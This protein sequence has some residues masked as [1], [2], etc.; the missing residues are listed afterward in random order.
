MEQMIQQITT[1]IPIAR[2]LYPKAIIHWVFDNSSAHGS[3]AKDAL[4]A[5]K[6]N[7]NPGGKVPDM[8]DTVIPL[9]NPYGHGGKIQKMTFDKDL[10]ADHPHKQFEG[11]PKGMK[12]ILS[13]RGYTKNGEGK[14]LIGECKACKASKSRKPHLEGASADEETAIYGEDGNDTD[15]ES[16]ERPVD[17]CMRR[18]LS[19]QPD[20][21]SEKSQLQLKAKALID[22]AL[23]LCPLP[24][25]RRFFRRANRYASVYR[26]GATGPLAEF[27]V[28]TFRSHRGVGRKDLE[29]AQ[30]KWDAR[31]KKG[32]H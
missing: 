7:V 1:A 4:T 30:A 31:A 15:D 28:K 26:L 24:T 5:T 29:V 25:I 16:D 21:A 12:V 17:C 2:R 3:L 23:R 19:L 22:E 10:P 13:E 9:D 27:A 8:H 14:P 32:V 6:M 18:L 11:L 20:F